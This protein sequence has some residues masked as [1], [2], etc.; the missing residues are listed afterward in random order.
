MSR[1]KDKVEIAVIVVFVANLLAYCSKGLPVWKS[2]GNYG[3]ILPVIDEVGFATSAL[4]FLF[5]PFCLKGWRMASV[6]VGSVVI[7]YLW[8]AGIACWVMVK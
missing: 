6:L 1:W 8:Y 2:L 3:T 5:A 7:G 4:T